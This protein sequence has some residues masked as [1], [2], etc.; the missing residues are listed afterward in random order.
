MSEERD[1]LVKRG[2]KRAMHLLERRDYSRKELKDKLTK[3]EYPEDIQEEIF[4]Y[5]DSYHYLDDCRV[6]GTF[7]RNRK[8]GKSKRELEYLLRQK[9]I[10][11]EDIEIAMDENYRAEEGEEQEMIA[12]YG[13]LRKYHVEEGDIECLNYEEKQKL[14][15]KLYRKGF[16]ADKIR[17]AL[18]M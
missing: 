6:A 4:A 10:S 7:I 16:S 18:Q 2:K 5:L 1:E 17:S 8:N 14:A 9:G 15:A 3:G 12:I 13:Q 11:E